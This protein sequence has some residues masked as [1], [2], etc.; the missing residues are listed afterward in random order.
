MS[1]ANK[2]GEIIYFVIFA[3]FLILRVSSMYGRKVDR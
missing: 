1:A 2:E 3:I